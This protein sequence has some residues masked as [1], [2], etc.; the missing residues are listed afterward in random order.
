MDWSKI[1]KFAKSKGYT[2]KDDAA[3]EVAA[4]LASKS[5]VLADEAG[6]DLDL[7]AI[8]KAHAEA[9]APKRV[10]LID[11]GDDRAAELEVENA[12]LKARAK[13]AAAV[14]GA[15][16]SDEEDKPQRFSIA[17]S[18]RKAYA[19]KIKNMGV[20][21]G[22]K[23]AKFADADTA[24]VCAAGIRL[25]MCGTKAYPQRANDL[26]IMQ[27]AQVEFDNTLGGYLV[28]EEFVAQLLY[29]TEPYGV[30]RRVANV[31]RMTENLQRLPRK[32]GIPTMAWVSEAQSTTV[33]NA[34]FDQ[35]EMA[36][37]E[38]QLIMSAS[39]PLLSD[40]AINVAD[41]IA[42]TVREA[43]D[44]ALD[45]AYFLGDGTSTYGGFTGLKNALP[46]SAY[47]TA[48]GAWTSYTTA[49]FHKALGSLENVNSGRIGMVMSRQAYFQICQRLDKAASQ[50]KDLITGTGA[51]GSFLGYPVFFSQVLPTATASSAKT[52]Y[53]GD[54]VGGSMIGERQD[55]TIASSEHTLFTTNSTAWRA[56]ARASVNIHGDGRGSTYGPI[57]CL[58][59]T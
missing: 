52:V 35:V 48:S 4:F 50:F 46:S 47:I 53:I 11:A 12:K 34:N 44:I 24:E 17:N 49:D 32:T 8:Q 39:N 38:L 57:V 18:A 51:D 3:G 54:F 14:H 13:G 7:V 45:S 6:A 58:V 36:A 55:L 26:E 37:R 25:A 5:I 21:K 22:D 56:N 27:K 2:G 20:G 33:Q 43:Y 28:P 10:T 1:L 40:A 31:R 30:A 41:E 16:N 29:L 9:T 42:T 59:N 23:Q 15:A 19:A